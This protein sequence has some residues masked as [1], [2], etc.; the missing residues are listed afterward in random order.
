M[1]L[2]E[3]HAKSERSEA[4]YLTYT[5]RRCS[6]CGK[7]KPVSQFNKNKRPPCARGWRWDSRCKKCRRA[8]SKTYG[9]ADRARRNAR[10]QRWRRAHPE[11]ARAVDARKYRNRREASL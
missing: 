5:H 8:E 2:L 3:R 6:I 11:A 4:G 7:V 9:A 10:L 1:R